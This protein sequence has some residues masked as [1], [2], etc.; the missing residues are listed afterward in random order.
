M[1]SLTA[2]DFP[3]FDRLWDY[4][5]P[6]RTE[7]A[8]RELLP[9][10]RESGDRNY[11]AQL[12]TQLA[13]T[14]G[15]QREFDEA[16]RTLDEAQS[17]LTDETPVARA[18]CLLERGRVFNTSGA[19]EK[20]RPLFLEALEVA[21]TAGAEG[22]AVDAAHMLGIVE[23]P[24]QALE[25]NLKAIAMAEAAR[26]EKARKWLGP[27]YNNTGWTYYDKGDY[28]KALDLLEKAQAFF[29]R[30]GNRGQIRIAKYSVG[31]ALRALGRVPEA[32]AVQEALQRE[33]DDAGERD[34]YV[35]E[36]LGECLLAQGKPDQARPHFAAAYEELSRDDWL[37]KNEPARL[38]R[39]KSLARL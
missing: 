33:L 28:P 37:V 25:W 9:K 31:K 18:R 1:S 35:R 17:L 29:V 22:Y 38:E 34:G 24:E 12:L 8:F 26:D 11:L 10:A 16:H 7:A 21:R 30:H 13:R 15:L 27:L 32:L 5:N 2:A 39:L 14:Q 36:E 4:G 23:P 3:D 20:S 6:P 19:P